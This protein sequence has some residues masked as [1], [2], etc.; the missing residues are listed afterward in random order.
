[1]NKGR[2][3]ET[4]VA[5]VLDGT[6]ATISGNEVHAERWHGFSSRPGI[7]HSLNASGFEELTCVCM[8]RRESLL[9]TPVVAE[10]CPMLFKGAFNIF[11][12]GQE[13]DVNAEIF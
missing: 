6:V 7:S 4:P 10:V 9:V 3:L 2:D 11:S 13:F 1:M 5:R 8:R 12:N